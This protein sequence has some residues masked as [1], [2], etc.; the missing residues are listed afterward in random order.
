[1]ER[2]IDVFTYFYQY[3]TP[4]GYLKP[5]YLHYLLVVLFLSHKKR[6]KKGNLSFLF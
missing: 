6:V 5:N 1:M 3:F 2:E 4:T